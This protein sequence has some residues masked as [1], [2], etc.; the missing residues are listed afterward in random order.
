MEQVQ[1]EVM[2]YIEYKQSERFVKKPKMMVFA[3]ETSNG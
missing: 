1:L 3:H 2:E